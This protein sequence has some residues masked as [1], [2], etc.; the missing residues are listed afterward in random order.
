MKELKYKKNH[1]KIDRFSCSLWIKTNHVK[2]SLL[3]LIIIIFNNPS[4]VLAQ[5][6]IV[7]EKGDL[8]AVFIDNS[9]YGEHLN[10]YNGISE[11]YHKDQDSTFFTTFH[12]GVNLE[13]IFGGD[14]LVSL[15]EPRKEPMT[16]E[17]LSDS[18]IILHQPET[19]ISHVESWTTFQM[20]SPHYIDVDLRFV[21]HDD[22]MFGHGYIGLFWASYIN[23]PKILGINI[24]GRN[25][26]SN[27]KS[28]WLYEYSKKHN[29]NAT[30]ISD[31]DDFEPYM[32]PNFNVGLAVD[33]SES[34]YTE[35][36]YYGLFHNM[37]FAYL[38]K[39]PKE[40]FIRFTKSPNGAGLGRPAWDFHYILPGFEVGKEYSIKLRVVYKKWTGQKNIEDE[41][42][43]WIKM[44][45]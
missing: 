18:K 38:F 37:V 2:I 4:V 39:E 24:K 10:G 41:Y 36:F 7:L 21:V 11:L 33:V 25:K 42:R 44:S 28:R 22:A 20:V 34:V 16:I 23:S 19:S 43:K 30:H 12:S 29:E 32:S 3:A 26:N 13:H 9:S 35:P 15:F 14:S 45:K 27:D 6:K 40:G 5:N 17:K 1:N 8:K 31:K